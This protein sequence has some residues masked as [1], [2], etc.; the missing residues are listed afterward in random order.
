MERANYE[1]WSTVEEISISQ[2]AYLWCGYEMPPDEPLIVESF[3]RSVEQIKGK[4]IPERVK[5]VLF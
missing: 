4:A 3:W 2:A 1:F 5:L